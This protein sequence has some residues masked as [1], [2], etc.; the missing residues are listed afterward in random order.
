M[1]GSGIA[2]VQTVTGPLAVDELGFT[3]PHEHLVLVE[4]ELN[5]NYPGYWDAGRQVPE[6]REHLRRAKALG[7]DTI[8]DMT[9]LGLGRDVALVRRIAEGSGVNVLVATGSYTMDKLSPFFTRRGPGSLLG[10]RDLLE[11]FFVRDLTEGVAD[12]GIRAALVKCATGPQGVTADVDRVIRAVAAAHRRTGAPVST[13][14]D[15]PAGREQLRI[16]TEEGVPPAKI[17]IGHCGDS[18]DLG[19]LTELMDAGCSIGMDRFGMDNILPTA[20]RCRVVAELAARGYAPRMMLSHDTNAYSANWE[21]GPRAGHIPDWNF[22]FISTQVLDRLRVLGVDQAA[23]DRMTIA[24]PR[25]L[26]S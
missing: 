22:E 13:H 2:T 20:E 5:L 6:A 11:E 12:T 14:A 23:I 17:V 18:T 3:L 26:F 1:T 7:V 16:L 4:T 9:V 24:N 15:P 21:P 10:G 25:D 19:Y 8:I